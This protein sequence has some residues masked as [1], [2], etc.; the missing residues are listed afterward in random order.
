MKLKEIFDQLTYGELSQL[1]IGGDEAG[2]ISP[3]NYDRVLAHVNLGLTALYKRF[4][5]KEGRVI[6]ELQAGRTTYPI[7]SRYA[8]TSRSSR[9][10]VRY[11]KDSAGAAF[12]D[13]IHKIER[14]YTSAGWEF[15]LN[16]EADHYAM[17]TPSATTLVVPFDVVAKPISLPD[18]LKTDTLEIVYRANHPILM[19]D[20]G[21]L[22]PE[23]V[24][25]ELPYSH[26]EPL[27]LFVASRAYTP[28]GMSADGNLGNTY[29]A[30]YEAACLQLELINLRV[31]Q[32]GQRDKLTERGW[33]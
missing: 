7:T 13:D 5:L 16:D 10:P 30:K 18:E 19:T 31:D 25:V 28:T 2:V 8:V 15:G 23:L 1:S 4:P 26:L 17:R 11:I 9:E 3:A 12:K 33:V 14:V 24:E 21:D 22:E 6:V 29:A 20:E 32:G 27:L